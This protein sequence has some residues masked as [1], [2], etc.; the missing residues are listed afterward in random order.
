MPTIP[1]VK[2]EITAKL[3]S[4]SQKHGGEGHSAKMKYLDKE[5]EKERERK[6]RRHTLIGWIVSQKQ[7]LQ[8]V[9][10]KVEFLK[11]KH[12]K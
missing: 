7:N 3:L 5:L 6:T 10:T 9:H 1:E 12:S 4:I 8:K 11:K 2:K